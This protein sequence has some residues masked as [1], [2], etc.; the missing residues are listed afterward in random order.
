MYCRERSF[1]IKFCLGCILVAHIEMMIIEIIFL[2][3][4]KFLNKLMLVISTVSL[5]ILF[6]MLKSILKADNLAG[7]R[8]DGSL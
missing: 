3:K 6:N 7:L 2:S 1:S 8:I 4:K 5:Y